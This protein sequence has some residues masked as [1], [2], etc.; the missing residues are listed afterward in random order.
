[1]DIEFDPEKDAL[2][3]A[4]H[5]GIGLA[6][7]REFDMDTALVAL[8]DRQDYGE[9]RWSAVGFIGADLHVL[10][11]TERHGRIRPI[12]L[13]KAEKSEARNYD[14]QKTRYGF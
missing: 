10:I 6:A 3:K 4:R 2:N 7:A 12:S 1:M 9:D 14:Q 8:D 13:R 5:G 11:F